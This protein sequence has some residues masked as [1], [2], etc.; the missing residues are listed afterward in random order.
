MTDGDWWWLFLTIDGEFWLTL[1]IMG[2]N[3]TYLGGGPYFRDESWNYKSCSCLSLVKGF[4]CHTKESFERNTKDTR[5]GP[6]SSR[7]SQQLFPEL[8]M[9]SSTRT[10]RC[11]IGPS[12]WCKWRVNEEK[13]L[14][15]PLHRIHGD[16]PLGFWASCKF[17]YKEKAYKHNLQDAKEPQKC[18]WLTLK[19]CRQQ[20]TMSE[21]ATGP[22]LSKLQQL[23]SSLD[24]QCIMRIS[25]HNCQIY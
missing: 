18:F 25:A 13:R 14:G 12:I 4:G 2:S 7:S 8:L 9:E 1:H 10:H 23:R 24:P 20:P 5:M 22:L 21:S 3:F 16:M 19:R 15:K 17:I 11:W 6:C